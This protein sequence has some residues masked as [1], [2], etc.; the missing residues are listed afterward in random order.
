L[1]ARGVS[2]ALDGLI[3]DEIGVATLD[4]LGDALTERLFAGILESTLRLREY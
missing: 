1:T 3:E 4:F 2:E